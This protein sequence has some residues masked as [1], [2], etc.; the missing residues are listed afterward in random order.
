MRELEKN[1]ARETDFQAAYRRAVQLKDEALSAFKLGALTLEERAKIESCYSHT[2]QNIT[3]R[4]LALG[5]IPEALN[6]IEKD[7]APKYLC[8]FSVFQSAADSWALDQVLPIVPIHRLD[9]RPARRCSIADITC[10]SDGKVDN[11]IENH[12][13]RKT[14]LLHDLDESEYYIGIFLT[15]AYQ[16]VMGD[17]HN[18]FGRLN[19]VHIFSDPD[20]PNGFYIEAVI[21]GQSAA[22]VLSTMQYNPEYMAYIVKK[23]IDGEVS[24][25]KI[26]PR[27]GVKLAD[28]YKDCLQDYTYFKP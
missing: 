6:G 14:V 2:I 11:F 22:D 25:G 15:G 26:Q 13:H 1:H 21:K 18:L 3:A 10:D 24:R 8:N 23:A 9:E 12:G 27:M 16:D 20:D 19:E 5:E 28:L 7:I 4:A 17:M